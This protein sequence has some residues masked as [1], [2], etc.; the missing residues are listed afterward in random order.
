MDQLPYCIAWLSQWRGEI[1][2]AVGSL[3][4]TFEETYGYEPGRNE[5]RLAGREDCRAARDFSEEVLGFEDLLTFYEE[6]AEVVLPDVGNGCFVHS[7]REVLDRLAQEG[8]VFLPEADDPQGM[9]IA[10]NGGGLLY[11]ADWGGAVHRSR[12][13]SLQDAEFD[14]VADSLP[15]FLDHIRHHVVRFV[16]TGA[17]GDL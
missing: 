8:P 5:V 3:L 17:T 7:A 6:I 4:S 9:V 2:D 12:T 1:T 11:V 14:K 10:S 13:A 16:E 15:E